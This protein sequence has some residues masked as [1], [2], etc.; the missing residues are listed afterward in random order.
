MLRVGI[1]LPQVLCGV[2]SCIKKLYFLVFIKRVDN[3]LN[4]VD[5]LH[6]IAFAREVYSFSSPQLGWALLLSSP[7]FLMLSCLHR[8]R[9]WGQYSEVSLCYLSAAP[10]AGAHP[11]TRTV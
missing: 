11:G 10:E 5:H 3:S 2:I 4:F 6:P 1:I 8:G 9:D 7:S